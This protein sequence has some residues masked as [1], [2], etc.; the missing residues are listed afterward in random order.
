MS[1]APRVRIVTPSPLTWCAIGVGASAIA[2][3]TAF[4]FSC[5]QALPWLLP[6]HFSRNGLPDMWQYKTYGRVFVPVFIQ[7]ALVVTLGAVAALLLS[8][9]HGVH[10]EQA[11]DVQA[12]AVAAEGVAL[13]TLIWVLFQGYATFAL[14]RMWQRERDGLGPV[15]VYLE[16]A[17]LLLTIGVAARTHTR[18]GHPAARPYVAEH[19]RYGQLYRNAADP[20]LF[21][22]TRNGSRWTL[23]FGRPV[24]VAILGIVLGIGIIGPT[25]ILAL[26]LR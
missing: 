13:I 18:L 19:W 12:A 11:P 1:E 15:Y 16:L 3:S 17:G 23:N 21:V 5:Y 10:D 26:V 14:A 22:P 2:F 8:R 9:A 20:A 7:L 25:V 6:V 24:A 4:I